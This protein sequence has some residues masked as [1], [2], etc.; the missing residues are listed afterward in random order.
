MG[1][2]YEETSFD[3]ITVFFIPWRGTVL[4]TVLYGP[5]IWTLLLIHC[6]LLYLHTALDIDEGM[7]VTPD[8]IYTEGDDVSK[9]STTLLLFFLV[10]FGGNCFTRYFEFYEACMGMQGAV[11]EWVG[12]MRIYLP[13]ANSEL[14]WALSRHMVASVYFLYFE[15]GGLPA[16]D[17]VK[18]LNETEWGVL[19]RSRLINKEER[20]VLEAFQGNRVHL[21]QTW[22]LRLASEQMVKAERQKQL[23]ASEK[24]NPYDQLEHIRT[25]EEISISLREH[26]HHITTLSKQP[27]PFPLYY[28]LMLMLNASLM[29]QA[30]AMVEARTF[31]SIPSYF[32][33]CFVCLGL[34]ETA[35][36][37]S[38]PFG[39][40][41]VDFE[42]DT[43]MSKMML[44][45]KELISRPY[46][47]A[48]HTIENLPLPDDPFGEEAALAAE[49]A[50]LAAEPLSVR[51]ERE[52]EDGRQLQLLAA[53][54]AES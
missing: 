34:K 7:I 32:L 22:G 41:S 2:E 6:V 21:L 46:H 26:G 54:H 15:E 19:S 38:D 30:Y 49:E 13:H 23:G 24:P 44:N 5:T 33:I 39:L 1:V 16:N 51:E 17:R 10:Y 47:L 37:L 42:T 4:R 36:A 8:D 29:V 11:Q 45:T 9:V 35:V 25:L 28:T 52:R 53:R 12:L 20:M 40:D 27:M 43:F 14:L 3:E 50:A 18:L 31:M 48:P